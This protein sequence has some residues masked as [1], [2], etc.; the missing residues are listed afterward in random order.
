M[1]PTPPSSNTSHSGQSPDGQFRVVRKRNRIP[2][3]CG[4]CRHRKLKCNRSHPCDNCIKRGDV[5]SCTYASPS[6][7]RKSGAPNGANGNP[8]EMQNR[9]DRLE[10]LVL[11]LMTNG[12]QS[13]G[14][15]AATAAI[16]GVGPNTGSS[17]S[18]S[19]PRFQL[20]SESVREE[21]EDGED[22]NESEVDK[23]SKQMGI[24]KMDSGKTIF[25]SEAHWYSILAEVSM[26]CQISVL[27]NY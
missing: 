18:G 19:S 16:T 2:L 23:M 9:I 21:L 24:M 1:T 14:P 3:S 4:P 20:D 26:A 22:G 17:I 12:A 15:T 5:E 10:S 7:R 6:A 13:A 8:D 27:N 11:S 25:A